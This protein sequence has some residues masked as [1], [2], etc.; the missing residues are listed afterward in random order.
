MGVSSKLPS[1]AN[2]G[3]C[4]RGQQKV[5]LWFV[6]IALKKGTHGKKPEQ[7]GKDRKISVQSWNHGFP[8]GV[9]VRGEG[10]NLNNWCLARTPVSI[11]YWD[12][13]PHKNPPLETP[14]ESRD[15]N[16]NR[17]EENREMATNRSDSRL[18]TQVWASVFLGRSPSWKSP[19]KVAYCQ[20]RKRHMNINNFF[21][22][23]PGGGRGSPER[24][25]RSQMF[26]CCVPNSRN[27]SIHVRWPGWPRNSLRI[28]WGQFLR[29]KYLYFWSY[30]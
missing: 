20:D 5:S 26:M 6:L 3:T 1:F 4:K 14:D 17:S 10:G 21:G 29:W 30:C 25:A 12:F 19:W 27:I 9:F 18:A 8:K 28:F 23:C 11:N 7:I 15:T 13:P 16:Q 2:F 24:V 22:D